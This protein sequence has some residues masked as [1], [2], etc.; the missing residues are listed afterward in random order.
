MFPHRGAPPDQCST[1]GKP[2]PVGM[3]KADAMPGESW[4]ARPASRPAEKSATILSAAGLQEK[5]AA[6]GARPKEKQIRE[7]RQ[8][9]CRLQIKKRQPSATV[10]RREKSP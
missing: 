8:T 5:I 4:P 3:D 2:T 9:A 10:C 1:A 6:Q 7:N